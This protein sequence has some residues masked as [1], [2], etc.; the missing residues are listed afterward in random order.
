[1]NKKILAGAAFVL[2]VAFTVAYFT[3]TLLSGPHTKLGQKTQLSSK[4]AASAIAYG[5]RAVLLTGPDSFTTYDYTT[6]KSAVIGGASLGKNGL[7][8]ADTVSV[9]PDKKFILFHDVLVT[10]G[11]V[12]ASQLTAAGQDP[13][14]DYWWIYNAA[15][16]SFQNLP[17]DTT[18]AK[19][20]GDTVYALEYSP[21]VVLNSYDAA[22]MQQKNSLGVLPS[23]NDFYVADHGF[24]LQTYTDNIYYTADNVINDQLFD[25]GTL[26]GITSDKKTA[27]VVKTQNKV[28]S[29]VRVDI[30]SNNAETTVASLVYDTPILSQS[31]GLVMYNTAPK[32]DYAIYTISSKE[33]RKLA[34]G[35]GA[36]PSAVVDKN[37]SPITPAAILASDA[38]IA[39]DSSGKYY[40]IGKDLYGAK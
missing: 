29:L 10:S 28:R 18:I 13:A 9:S 15:N 5:A 24:L 35:S 8:N 23:V 22:T 40:V 17:A 33:T 36:L 31:L 3:I 6:G 32:G 19:L 27:F 37:T 14:G 16:D 1:M 30:S 21:G 7:A 11:G 39:S 4:N 2:V 26:V 20:S 25:S 38:I 34:F 12:L